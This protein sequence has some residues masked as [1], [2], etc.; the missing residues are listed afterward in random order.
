MAKTSGL[1]KAIAEINDP[2]KVANL[3]DEILTPNEMKDLLLRWKLMEMLKSG[4]SQRK[5]ASQLGVSL[6]KITRGSKILKD[7]N[8]VMNE[9]LGD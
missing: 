5:I 8:S 3:L 7:K 6:C 4:I 2:E 9:I 1:M